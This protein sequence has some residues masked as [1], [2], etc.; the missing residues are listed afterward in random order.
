MYWLVLMCCGCVVECVCEFVCAVFCVVVW[1][2][3]VFLL[4]LFCCLCVY[5]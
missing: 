3:C 2:G 1:F 5:L 4:L